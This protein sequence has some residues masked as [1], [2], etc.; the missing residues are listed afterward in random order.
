MPVTPDDKDWTWVLDR[1]CPDCGFDAADHPRDALADDVR[2][3]APAWVA[4]LTRPDVRTR[5]D[6]ATWSV[7]EYGCH[8]RDVFR[9]FDGRLALLLAE[10]DPEFANWDQ[11][12]TAVADHYA[13]QDPATVADD[14][15]AAADTLAARFDSVSGAAWSRTGRRSDGSRFTVETLGTYL[16]HDPVHHLWDV[17]PD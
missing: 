14:L 12:T 6:D 8:V 7:L 10:D 9:I 11:D 2:T 4:E 3:L 1:P 16:V 17:R 15:V 13:L 5:P